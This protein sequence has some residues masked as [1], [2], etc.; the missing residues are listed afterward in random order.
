MALLDSEVTRIKQ[1][2]GFNLLT[3]GALPYIGHASIFEQVIQPYL[4][5]GATT[6]SATAVTAA[7][8]YTPVAITLASATGFSAG[9]RVV[10]DV[11]TRQEI[12]TVQSITGA[13]I[14]VQLTG[15]H[16][17][18]YPVTVD[19][20]ETVIREILGRLRELS[21]QTGEAAGTAGI[22]KVSSIEFFGDGSSSQS[23]RLYSL[24]MKQ[25]DELASALGIPNMWRLRQ[26]AGQRSAL[27]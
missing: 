16:S 9:D 14:T 4:E 20:G 7:T 1:E 10:I 15:V 27:Y 13:A 17:G 19:G 22:K 5:A 12:A 18:T 21:E 3:I 6:T 24:R 23:T 11:D 8:S 26:S 25:R 2:L